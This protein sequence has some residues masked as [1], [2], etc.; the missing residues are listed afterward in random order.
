[1][2]KSFISCLLFFLF[3]DLP[4]NLS[5]SSNGQR[6]SSFCPPPLNLRIVLLGKDVSVNS[7]VGNLMLCRSAF[8]TE[9]SPDDHH[10][11]ERVR[12]KHMTLINC[13]HLL[14]QN[15][16]YHQ[17][18]DG[19][20]ECVSMC[21][22]GPHVIILILQ[23]HDF[24]Q[25]D[26]NR[27]KHVLNVCGDQAMKHTIVLTTDEETS[28]SVLQN[29]FI[30]ELTAE[31][32]GG[33]LHLDT[34]T[35]GWSSISHRLHKI[36]E[37]NRNEYLRCNINDE[38]EEEG[39]SVDEEL[40]RS[41]ISEEEQK[42]SDVEEQHRDTQSVKKKATTHLHHLPIIGRYYTEQSPHHDRSSRGVKFTSQQKLNLVLCGA[43]E[44]LKIF[45]S[46]LI[47]GKKRKGKSV[48]VSHERERE[49]R[50]VCVKREAEVHE[51]L[52]NVVSLP[53]LTGLSD[54]E[55]MHQTL[56]CVSL[57]G[58]GVHVFLII[59]PGAPLTDQHKTEL[60]EIQ[61]LFSSRINKH[62][63]TVIIKDK[64]IIGRLFSKMNIFSSSST[65][66]ETSQLFG[67]G[68]FVLERS[69]QIASL[70]Q[71]VERMRQEN[72]GR[73]YTTFMYLQA[74]IERE[75]NKHRAEIEKLRRSTAGVT[76]SGDD[77][78]RIVLLGKT[79]VGKSASGNTILRRD[80]FKSTIT[81]RS[82]TRECQKETSEY[83]KR[84]ITVIDT[85]GLFDTAVDNVETRKEIVKCVSMA[86]PGP[87]VFLLVLQLGRF[88]QEEKDAVKMIQET[89]GDKSR[90]YT[91][92]LF[93]RGD[94]LK[95]TTFEDFIKDDDS[96]QSIVRQC[97]NRYHVFNNNETK[98]HSQVSG[99][100]D[101]IDCMVATNGDSFYTNDMFQLA[102][103]N[104]KEEQERIMK[105]KEDEIKRKQEELKAIYEA[106][107]E[108]MK[109]ENRREGKEM[110][111]ELRR[112]EKEFKTREEEIKKE[113]DEN[114][115]KEL[116]RKLE[117]QQKEFEEENK[118]KEK[119]LKEQPQ[120]FIR[121]L[122]EKHERE[123]QNL[124]DRIQKETREQA[125]CD[126]LQKLDDE[127]S[128]ALQHAEKKLPSRSKRARDWSIYGSFVGAAAGGLIGSG[129]DLV[130]WII[131][132]QFD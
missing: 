59:I 47:R 7:R 35:D 67:G 132:K 88:T 43:D 126:Y 22:P 51:R 46:K 50:T 94:D 58:P 96:L 62:A 28:T 39:S 130:E 17:I 104:I 120:N 11:T 118:R 90:M 80:A 103:K 40:S 79:A 26:R 16:L 8:E 36:L 37:E 56:N 21:D 27:V 84:K 78:L 117:E 122:E 64:N 60:Q 13:P 115:Q 89:F 98:D 123:K 99:L 72:S 20:K 112:S 29:E 38:T 33:H 81:S 30:N 100:L 5:A 74:Q 101:K 119:A 107:T 49:S 114:L 57:C 129:E 102:E 93:T 110:Q 61:S 44:S 113:T 23:H 127:V 82:V 15:L 76:H 34:D 54:E 6:R 52:I 106:E 18:T 12:G 83:N 1:M 71:D 116:Q 109:K 70:L 92:I 91:M 111:R 48:S 14:Q 68:V 45:I 19:V 69:T 25:D 24:S 86:A 125:E 105:E 121:Y 77:D 85:P 97:G 10:C 124:K 63:I 66:V 4:Q 2:L 53:A 9:S 131:S 42:E 108:K 3:S 73:C 95:G 31:C 32:A 65:E 87:H 128:K 55:M 41:F 75:R